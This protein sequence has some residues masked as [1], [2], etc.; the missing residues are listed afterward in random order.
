M[1]ELSTIKVCEQWNLD[2]RSNGRKRGTSSVFNIFLYLHVSYLKSLGSQ[3]DFNRRKKKILINFVF[4]LSNICH[5]SHN[6]SV[7]DDT[8]D[9]VES[10]PGACGLVLAGLGGPGRYD[11]HKY[12]AAAAAHAKRL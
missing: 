11:A 10:S 8:L 5:V 1:M 7:L 6:D 4:L 3:L 12:I 2:T 9:R